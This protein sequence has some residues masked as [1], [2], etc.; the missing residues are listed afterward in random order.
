MR[1]RGAITLFLAAAALAAAGCG[2]GGGGK[3]DKQKIEDAVAAYYKAFG[4]GDSD[5]ACSYLAKDTAKELEKAGGGQDC[6]KLLA[7]ALK[8]PDYQRIST[9]LDKVKV[10]SVRVT[11]KEA[12]VTTEVPGI[13]PGSDPVSQTVPMKKEGSDWK[14]ASTVGE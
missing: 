8:R 6:P 13:G 11:G 7:A 9:Q 12:T 10:T 1:A 3:S 4:S 14:I 5:T 2:G